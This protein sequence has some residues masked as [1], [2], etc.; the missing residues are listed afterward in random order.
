VPPGFH[1]DD[2]NVVASCR[3]TSRSA[4]GN[5][6]GAAGEMISSLRHDAPTVV[7]GDDSRP[8]VSVS[9]VR[10]VNDRNE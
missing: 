1:H 9:S 8:P 6:G 2:V 10:V 3:V 4:L 7:H 5:E